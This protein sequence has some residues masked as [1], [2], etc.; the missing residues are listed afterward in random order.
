MTELSARIPSGARAMTDTTAAIPKRLWI[1]SGLNIVVAT[2]SLAAFALMGLGTKWDTFPGAEA[3]R[4][5]FEFACP[6]VLIV[7]SGLALARVRPARIVV[8][9]AAILFYGSMILP[10]LQLIVEVANAIPLA[11]RLRISGQI[12]TEAA[13]IGL[14]IWALY[15]FRVTRFLASDTTRSDTASD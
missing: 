15:S 5:C 3:G 10:N 14:N 2:L 9:I 11:T 6:A 1:A 4:I 7:T 12:A 8:T 13:A